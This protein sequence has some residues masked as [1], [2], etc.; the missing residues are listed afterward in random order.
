[1]AFEAGLRELAAV[2]EP[3]LTEP[4]PVPRS[5]VLKSIRN[6]GRQWSSG[7]SAS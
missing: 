7:R 2:M 1:M 4:L 3:T 6:S 5:C